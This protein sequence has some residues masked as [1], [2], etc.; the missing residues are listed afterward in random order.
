MPLIPRHMLKVY[1]DVALTRALSVDVDVVAMSG[2]FARGNENNLHEPDGTYYLG[3]GSTDPY[4][5]VSLGARY[6]LRPWIELIGQVNNLF[7]REY[8]T[9]AQLGPN[10]FTASGAFVARP[11]PPVNGEF[12]V[13]QST[14]Y[15]PG[16]PVRAWGG[17]RVRFKQP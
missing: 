15:A 4:A 11:L 16:A 17:V 7:D 3:P 1:A 12:P 9:A 13:T 10:A 5:V 8:V 6:A 14:F 2:A